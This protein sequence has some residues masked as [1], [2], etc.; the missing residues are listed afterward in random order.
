ME[1]EVIPTDFGKLV[2]DEMPGGATGRIVLVNAQAEKLFG[3]N[4]DELMRP[5]CG[6]AAAAA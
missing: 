1:P 3:Y 4:A 2:L 6:N 5:A